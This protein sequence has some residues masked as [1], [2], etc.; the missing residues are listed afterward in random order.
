MRL[1]VFLCI[2]ANAH[3]FT[4]GISGYSGRDGKVC[5]ECHTPGAAAKP[6]A[7]LKGPAVLAPGA[8]AEYQLVI[9]TDV[10][11]AASVSRAA[12]I[13]IAAS[14]G[15]TL[16]TVSQVNQTRLISGEISHTT[17]LPS[18]KTIAISFSVTAPMQGPLTIFAAALSVDSNGAT[19]GDSLATTTLAVNVSNPSPPDL[20]SNPSADLAEVVSNADLA[21]V[22]SNAD[23]GNVVSSADLASNADLADVVSAA[24]PREKPA[25]ADLGPP[26]NEAR[27]ACGSTVGAM[28]VPGAP[29]GLVLV[30]ALLLRRKLS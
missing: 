18:A 5:T 28:A 4:T 29:L 7:T 14:A 3:A 10:T 24:S 30:L 17:A 26:K 21:N 9:D 27:W 16:A 12:G 22:V 11:S 8:S 25:T 15:T 20:A 19:S 2:A 6:S 23:L 13:D 1:G